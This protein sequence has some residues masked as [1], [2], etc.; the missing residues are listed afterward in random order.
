MKGGGYQLIYSRN[1]I[2]FTPDHMKS[3]CPSNGEKAASLD[4]DSTSWCIPDGANRWRWEVAPGS[5]DD[6]TNYP[7]D[8]KYQAVT[9]NIPDQ[10]KMANGGGASVGDQAVRVYRNDPVGMH[11]SMYYQRYTDPNGSPW[12]C[13][14]GQASWFGLV[15][16]GQSAGDKYP[17]GIGGHCDSCGGWGDDKE[18]YTFGSTKIEFFIGSNNQDANGCKGHG[19]TACALCN[20]NSRKNWRYRFWTIE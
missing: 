1:N 8:L 16:A 20:D 10:A 9:T 7:G 12:G 6:V 13:G 19:G 2:F 18:A 14:S 3:V 11:N 17:A 5:S 15:V 4:K